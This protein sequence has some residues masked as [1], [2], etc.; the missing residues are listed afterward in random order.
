MR[1]IPTRV[2]TLPFLAPWVFAWAV[3]PKLALAIQVAAANFLFLLGGSQSAGVAAEHEPSHLAAMSF[4]FK[5][6]A[7][8]DN[9]LKMLECF[10]P[11]TLRVGTALVEFA[12]G[13]L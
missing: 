11:M 1:I 3:V 4:S 5:K 13:L 12:F 2:L 7:V 9:F 10:L 8:I 6:Q